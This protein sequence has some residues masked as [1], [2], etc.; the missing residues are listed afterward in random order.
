MGTTF[1][2]LI[3]AGYP[4]FG[5]DDLAADAL[6]KLVEKGLSSA[7]VVEDGRYVTMA[8]LPALVAGKK[9]KT[10][11]GSMRLDSVPAF[12][13]D[14]QLFEKLQAV[15]VISGGALPVVDEDGLYAGVVLK[16]DIFKV[17]ADLFHSGEGSSSIEIEVPPPGAK[18]SEVI[19]TI[20]KNDA[21]IVSLGS[22]P[23]VGASGVGQILF[24][25]VVSHDFYR[26]VRNLENYGYIIRYH[27]PIPNG[28]YDELREKALEFIRYMD[29]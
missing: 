17:I 25:R 2:S 24:F 7:P 9:G 23:A 14:E 5:I 1:A 29:M 4:V 27:S 22:R 28:G 12:G 8:M 21:S 26:L 11:L 16:R 19:A 15:G 13:Q 20:E 3:D 6:K 18:L 10:S